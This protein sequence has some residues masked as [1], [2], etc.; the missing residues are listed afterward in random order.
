MSI[1]KKISDALDKTADTVISAGYDRGPAAM[2]V[3]NSASR[4][5]LRRHWE[6]CDDGVDCTDPSHDH[7]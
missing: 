1:R 4:V 3:A 5:I 2:A 7:A 6:R